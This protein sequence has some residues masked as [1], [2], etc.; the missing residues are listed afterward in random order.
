MYTTMLMI[1]IENKEKK[2]LTSDSTS[3]VLP[4]TLAS[5]Y[6]PEAAAFLLYIM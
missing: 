5:S 1:I 2:K 4:K 3:E 6:F